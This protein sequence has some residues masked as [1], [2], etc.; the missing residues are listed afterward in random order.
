MKERI[1]KAR[2]RVAKTAT[3]LFTGLSKAK[4]RANIIYAGCAVLSLGIALVYFPAGVIA[5]GVCILS[6]GYYWEDDD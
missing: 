2:E 4:K 1:K 5:A 3:K 6:I